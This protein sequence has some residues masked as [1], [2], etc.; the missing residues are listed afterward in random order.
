MKIGLVVGLVFFRLT[1]VGIETSTS[2]PSLLKKK[3]KSVETNDQH[4]SFRLSFS[5][6]QSSLDD[7]PLECKICSV[8]V[9]AQ[10][11]WCKKTITEDGNNEQTRKPVLDFLFHPFFGKDAIFFKRNP[12][13][14]V[15]NS[16]NGTRKY[17]QKISI[18]IEASHIINSVLSR[19]KYKRTA[20]WH[21][22]RFGD[23]GF[24]VEWQTD[25]VVICFVLVVV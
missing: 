14:M 23:P 25:V 8:R 3:K 19:I 18:S 15:K 4:S 24:N 10:R 6:E 20:R 13:Q 7:A 5:I 17:T 9:K 22:E 2:P 1:R 21:F 11:S 12:P 16:R